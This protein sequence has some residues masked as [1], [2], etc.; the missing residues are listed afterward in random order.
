ML[1]AFICGL[2]VYLSFRLQMRVGDETQW[3]D[4]D[5][6]GSIEEVEERVDP[7]VEQTFEKVKGTA[8]GSLWVTDSDVPTD[9][10]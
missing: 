6:R 2:I 10:P 9:S 7:I 5:A 4:V 3:Y 8:L 1:G